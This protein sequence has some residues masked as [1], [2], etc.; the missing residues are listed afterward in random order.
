MRVRFLMAGLL[1][2][3]V[4]GFAAADAGKAVYEKSCKGCHGAAGQGNPGIAKAMKVEMRHLGSAEVQGKSDAD[5]KKV[6]GEGTG[7][8]KPV[9][10]VKGAAVDDVVSYLRTLKK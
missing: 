5:L 2:A 4:V 8:M 10:A 9:A 6:I 3:A 1:V 7:K